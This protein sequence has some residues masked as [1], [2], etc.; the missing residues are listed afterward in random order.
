MKRSEIATFDLRILNS[1]SSPIDINNIDFDHNM[2][3]LFLF[4]K[5]R[6]AMTAV[7]YDQTIKKLGA[8]PEKV[9]G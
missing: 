6:F 3:K 8:I 1:F 2:P 5:T 7:S 4:E 9:I